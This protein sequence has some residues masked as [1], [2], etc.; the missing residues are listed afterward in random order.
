[1]ADEVRKG[2]VKGGNSR[3]PKLD[4]PAKPPP[5]SV[6]PSEYKQVN[7]PN[8]RET[9]IPDP[10]SLAEQW[11]YARR[12]YA[13]YYSYAWGSAI[14]VG[15]TFYALGWYIKGED[16]LFGK[17]PPRSTDKSNKG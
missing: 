4:D 9:K 17:Q 10:A 11:Q 15:A 8:P 3:Q 16:P 7:F 12:T 5:P 1:M 13:K 6:H 14:L 2:T